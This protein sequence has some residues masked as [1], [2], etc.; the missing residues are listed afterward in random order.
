MSGEIRAQMTI[1][2]DNN[3][4]KF[5]KDGQQLQI[6]QAAP[7]GGVPG[8]VIA[9]NAAQGVAVSFTGLTT[10]GWLKM[11]NVDLTGIIEWGP[12]DG[13]NLIEMGKMLPGEEAMFRLAAAVTLRLRSSIATNKVQVWG[14]ET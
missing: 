12:D 11:R 14:F 2:V 8:T 1:Q 7:G 5:P 13:G 3:N 6:D 10:P 9:T 4:F